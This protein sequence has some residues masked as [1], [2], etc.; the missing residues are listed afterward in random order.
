MGEVRKMNRNIKHNK[1]FKKLTYKYRKLL[2]NSYNWQLRNYKTCY[3]ISNIPQ[4]ITL[5]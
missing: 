1:S 2:N 5:F 4:I 3:I